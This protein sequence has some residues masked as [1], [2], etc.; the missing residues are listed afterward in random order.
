MRIV[1]YLRRGG[2]VRVIAGLSVLVPVRH[3]LV[4][5]TAQE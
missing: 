2:G 4:D 5:T 1:T 3:R